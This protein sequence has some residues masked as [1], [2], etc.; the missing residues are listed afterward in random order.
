MTRGP[1]FPRAPKRHNTTMEF[2]GTWPGVGK[3]RPGF[4][5]MWASS[6]EFGPNQVELICGTRV[7]LRLLS[8]F[9]RPEMLPQMSVRRAPQV[10]VDGTKRIC[11]IV[12][13]MHAVE[14]P[15]KRVGCTTP[16]LSRLTGA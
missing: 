7:G 16:H 6:S 3:R 12:S 8:S 11:V 15:H 14:P 5:Q 13:G 1:V 9:Q 10:A 4:G 2:G